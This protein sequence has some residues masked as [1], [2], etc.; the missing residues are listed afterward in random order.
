VGRLVP[1]ELV[2]VPVG[3][4]ALMGI[5]ARPPRVKE[6]TRDWFGRHLASSRSAGGDTAEAT[7]Q[8]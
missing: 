4:L 7:R 1:G 2:D 6:L 3:D 8:G 5:L